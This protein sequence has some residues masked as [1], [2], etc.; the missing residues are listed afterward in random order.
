MPRFP[1]SIPAVKRPAVGAVSRGADK[2]DIF[3][4]PNG[5]LIVT[6]AWQPDFAQWSPW[7]QDPARIRKAGQNDVGTAP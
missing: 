2:I 1:A 4:V 5:N 6:S 7:R 3:A